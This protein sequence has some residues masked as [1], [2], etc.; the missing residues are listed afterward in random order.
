METINSFS[1]EFI[2]DEQQKELILEVHRGEVH[3]VIFLNSPERKIFNDFLKKGE[4]GKIFFEN[5][6]INLEPYFALNK[7]VGILLDETYLLENLT[8]AE[9]LLIVTL[10]NTNKKSFFNLKPF[11]RKKHI[12]MKSKKMLKNYEID[13]DPHKKVSDISLEEKRLLMITKIFFLKPEI[14]VLFEPTT[15][16]SLDSIKLVDSMI[17]NH[18]N[19]GKGILYITRSW[20]EALRIGDKIS[21]IINGELEH[22]FE[23]SVIRNNPKILLQYI[24]GTDNSN[25]DLY[26]FPNYQED[27]QLIDSVFEATEYLTSEYE[28][29]DILNF[30]AENTAKATRADACEISLIDEE[31][32]TIIDKSIYKNSETIEFIPNE[33]EILKLIDEEK[34]YYF[35]KRDKGFERFFKLTNDI[36]SLICVPFYIRSRLGGIIQI[37]YKDYHL[38][39]EEEIKYLE[40]IAHQTALAI[41][42]TKLMGN[43]VLL[44]ESHHRIKN[45]LQS[46]ISLM[47]IYK[48]SFEKNSQK[49]VSEMLDDLISKIKSIAA[50][51]DLLSK[52]KLGRS[53][54]NLNEMII[55]IIKFMRRTKDKIEFEYDLDNIFVS[56]SKA[57]AIALVVNEIVTNSLKYAFLEKDKGKISIICKQS[58]E[59]ISIEVSDNGKGFP[60]NFQIT[61]NKGIGLSIVYSIV[62]K[63]LGGKIRT[64]NDHGAKVY[65]EI[66]F[67]QDKATIFEETIEKV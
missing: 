39:T 56:Y 25:K 16:L 1:S 55:Q 7:K 47:S 40:T 29:N 35:T 57:S 13:L 10:N 3:V 20:E 44:K 53:I 34:V 49:E 46:I 63:Q 65:I 48:M 31:T 67:K 11:L 38:Y 14:V 32:S 26:L 12:E 58:N 15:H 5:K 23:S 9:N 42:N 54:I 2:K 4:K 52:D 6:I 50:V 17:K 19:M 59:S 28:L 33:A 61:K 43:S 27:N 8:I 45:N 37:Y 22:T 62:T 51:H 30:L 24:V 66:P 41:H 21:V 60:K 64:E 18:K 36:C